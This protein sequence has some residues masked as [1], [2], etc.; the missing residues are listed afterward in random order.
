MKKQFGIVAEKLS[1]SLSPIIHN[2]WLKQNKII[3]AYKK[4]ELKLADIAPFIEKFKNDNQYLGFNVTIPYKETFFQYCNKVTKRAKKI[5]S[6]NLIYKNKNNIIGDNTD[7]LGFKKTYQKLKVK[8]V[9]NVLLIGAGG[10]ARAVLYTLNAKSIENIDIFTRTLKRKKSI[11]SDFKIKK[12]TNKTSNLRKNYDVIINSS[13]AGMLHQ[14]KM[15]KPILKLVPHAKYIIDIVYNPLQTELI[16][17]ANKNNIPC[18][19]G[20]TMLVEQAKPSFKKWFKKTPQINQK[21]YSI[22]EKKLA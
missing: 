6:I 21:L 14:D 20:L 2:Y 3:A 5:K 16:T 18:M 13:S 4:R 1:H 17:I 12:F 9:K 15:K 8:N 7:A 10:A 22:L 19:G 11:S